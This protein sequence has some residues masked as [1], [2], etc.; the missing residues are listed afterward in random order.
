MNRFCDGHV[1]T[2]V[3]IFANDNLCIVLASEVEIDEGV[4]ANLSVSSIM[5]GDRTLK[6]NV[7]VQL[8]EDF[9][10]Y[11]LAS[12]GLVLGQCIV[13]WLS[14]WVLL[15]MSILQSSVGK[16]NIPFPS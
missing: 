16:N 12:F 1:G 10:Q 5:K 15:L 3:T 11:F 13:F 6:Y 2:E 4:F 9:T 7:F 8:T 14:I